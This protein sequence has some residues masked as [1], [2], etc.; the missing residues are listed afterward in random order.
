M[1][2]T[3]KLLDSL[4]A[5]RRVEIYVADISLEEAMKNEPYVHFLDLP[6]G[7]QFLQ[8][9]QIEDPLSSLVPLQGRTQLAY[10]WMVDATAKERP[11]RWHFTGLLPDVDFPWHG[12]PAT[13]HPV[14]CTVLGMS[15]HSGVVVT[16]V[17][18]SVS[19]DKYEQ[20]EKEIQETGYRLVP[21][22]RYDR[23]TALANLYKARSGELRDAVA[24]QGQRTGAVPGVAVPGA[25][26]PGAEGQGRQ[27]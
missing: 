2:D 17:Q 23:A 26:D 25:E 12:P 1:N 15:T 6:R 16:H 22:K 7:S 4:K 27:G 14:V 20:F 13:T 18:T 24:K 11:E 10:A 21:M 8:I 9:V 3:T 19:P 5:Q